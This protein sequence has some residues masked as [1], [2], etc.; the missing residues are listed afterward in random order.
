MQR[1]FIIAFTEAPGHQADRLVFPAFSLVSLVRVSW[2]LCH[3]DI[4]ALPRR[5]QEGSD[6]ILD[7]ILLHEVE[8]VAKLV[9]S[10]RTSRFQS[11]ACEF[12]GPATRGPHPLTHSHLDVHPDSA[13]PGS[14]I[15]TAA[16]A[17]KEGSALQPTAALL[18]S[19]DPAG[20]ELDR[21]IAGSEVRCDMRPFCSL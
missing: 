19:D 7:D 14:T 6:I 8:S 20:R 21:S 16:A 18:I 1:N 10:K 15:I 4:G 13:R 12:R 17:G 2:Q 11:I 3:A 9:S 5:Q